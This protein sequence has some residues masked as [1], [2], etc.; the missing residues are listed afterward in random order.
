MPLRPDREHFMN[1]HRLLPLL[2]MLLFTPCARSQPT[3]PPPPAEY[4][5]RIHQIDALRN[6]ASNSSSRSSSI[7]PPSG[8]RR[9]TVPSMRP[10]TPR[11]PHDRDR[12]RRRAASSSPAQVRTVLL[13]PKGFALPAEAEPVRVQLELAGD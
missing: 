11:H 7:S 3:A 2:A 12:P 1:R 9:M 8:S 10:K 13:I 5:A 4:D 6:G